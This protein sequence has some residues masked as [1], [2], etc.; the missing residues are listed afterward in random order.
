MEYIDIICNLCGSQENSPYACGPD[1]EYRCTDDEFRIVKCDSCGFIYLNP[2]PAPSELYTIYPDNYIPYRF[3]DY[4][5]G[6][7]NSL[8]M[9]VQRFK[10]K[11]LRSFA[12]P[13]AIIWDVGCGG[14]FFLDCLHKFGDP[15]WRLTGVD[16]SEKAVNKV[17][18]KGFETI[19]GRFETIDI[20][21]GSVDIVVLNQVIEHLNNPAA[22]VEKASYVLRKGGHIFIETP[23]IEGWDARIFKSRHWGGWHFP[24]HWTFFSQQTLSQLL[25]EKGFD[26]VDSTWLLSPNFWAQSCHHWLIDKGISERFADMIDCKNPI[27]LALFSTVDLIQKIFRHTSNMRMV[28]LKY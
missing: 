11:A 10:V 16:I 23:S 4:L 27:V 19:Q 14:G 9:A 5:S 17:K 25:K 28:G 3:D 13:A 8:R 12:R 26:V 6:F 21:P 22:V 15:T 2:R 1:F 24:R 7:T 20:E 18:A